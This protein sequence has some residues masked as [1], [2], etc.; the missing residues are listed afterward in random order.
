MKSAEGRMN[1]AKTRLAVLGEPEPGEPADVTERRAHYQQM[2]DEASTEIAEAQQSML[3]Y[4]DD[5]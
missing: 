2:L 3:P 5:D 1:I 4:K